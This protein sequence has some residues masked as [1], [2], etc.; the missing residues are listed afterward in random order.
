LFLAA[1]MSMNRWSSLSECRAVL[2]PSRSLRGYLTKYDCSSGTENWLL[3][4]TSGLTEPFFSADLNP[5][6]GISKA[7]LKKFIAYAEG[8]FDLPILR[9]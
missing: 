7:D 9:G 2:T 5:I 1:P 3:Y 4:W 6:G 8:A